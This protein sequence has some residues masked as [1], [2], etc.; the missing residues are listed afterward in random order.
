MVYF[1]VILDYISALVLFNMA[2]T[3]N[4]KCISQ[5]YTRCITLNAIEIWCGASGDREGAAE[6]ECFGLGPNCSSSR[7][8]QVQVCVPI[9]PYYTS[10]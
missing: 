3:I 8:M 5:L 7:R 1:K 2:S 6:F 9:H 4:E 10:V